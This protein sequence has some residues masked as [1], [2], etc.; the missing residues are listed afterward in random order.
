MALK[1]YLTKAYDSLE[2]DFIYDTL[3]FF[4]VP[5][6]LSML[7]WPIQLLQASKFSGMGDLVRLFYHLETLDKGTLYPHIFLLCV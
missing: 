1:V 6:N 2:C 4:S 7:L 3:K 5:V